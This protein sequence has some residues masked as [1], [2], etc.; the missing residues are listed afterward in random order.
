MR[1]KRM[2]YKAGARPGLASRKALPFVNLTVADP[3]SN[4]MPVSV[5]E[6][7]SPQSWLT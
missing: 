1:M 7:L 3:S 6:W 5:G 4:L 2:C